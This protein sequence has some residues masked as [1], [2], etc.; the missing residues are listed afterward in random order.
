MRVTNTD[1][2]F[3]ND[4]VDLDYAPYVVEGSGDVEPGL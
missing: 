2:I 3:G 1:P 4:V